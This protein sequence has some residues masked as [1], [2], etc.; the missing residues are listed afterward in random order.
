M[1]EFELRLVLENYTT[2]TVLLQKSSLTKKEA[3][4]PLTNSNFQ[5][6][7]SLERCHTWTP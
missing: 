3:I 1:E 7:V 2:R 4:L 6:A 5:T